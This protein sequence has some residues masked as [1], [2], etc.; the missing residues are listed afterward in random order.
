MDRN[1]T[2]VELDPF[3]AA[4]MLKR[5]IVCFGFAFGLLLLLFL[6]GEI[7]LCHH[8]PSFALQYLVL[9]YAMN[10]RWSRLVCLN[11]VM[12]SYVL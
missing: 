3:Y 12:S 6:P 8:L 9:T 5:Y 10:T 1:K 11:S 7:M 4:R 2:I